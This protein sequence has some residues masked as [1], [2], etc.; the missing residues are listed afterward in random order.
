MVAKSVKL[1]GKVVRSL[2]REIEIWWSSSGWRRASSTDLGNSGSS[3]RKR[4][5]R[6]AREISP[7]VMG[8]PPPIME[9]AELL[10]WG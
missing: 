6:C 4:M 5:P 7:G 1:A 2:A 3:S 10:W 8:L 9:Q